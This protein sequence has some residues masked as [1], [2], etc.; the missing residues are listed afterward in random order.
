MTTRSRPGRSDRISFW[1]TNR[2]P[3]HALTAFMGWFSRIESRW[4]TRASVTVW[5]WFVDDLRLFESRKESFVSLHE[6]FTRQLK[7]GARPVDADPDHSSAP[8]TP[9][10]VQWA[11]S[12]KI[13]CS[14]PRGWTTH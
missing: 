7:P 8:V 1:L 14:R 9:K 4:L 6:C 2:I 13:D 3:R 10:S 11:G 5:Q 12:S